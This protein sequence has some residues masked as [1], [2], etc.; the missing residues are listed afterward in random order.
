MTERANRTVVFITGAGHSGTT[1]LGLLLGAH[2]SVF[3]AG[4]AWNSTRLGAVRDDGRAVECTCCGAGCP[5]WGGL[6]PG[7]DGLGL[8][9]SPDLY[10]TLSVR[11]GR[12]VVV[13]SSKAVPWIEARS[14]A[15]RGV[16]PAHLLLLGRDGRAVVNSQLR[17]YP[18]VPARE[19]AARWAAQIR[20]AEELAG[21]WP[22]PVSRLHYE[23]LA[24]MTEDVLQQ[25]ARSLGLAFEPAMLDPWESEQHPLGGNRGTHSLLA[26][27]RGARGSRASC[28]SCA[29]GAAEEE[30][31]GGAGRRA[32]YARHPPAVV[33]DLRWHQEMPAD[34]LA[35]FDEVAGEVNIPYAR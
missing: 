11:S 4:E 6:R 12:P 7:E 31:P 3:H 35:V 26:R 16:V 30:F 34:A 18:H 2:P 17:K 24:M 27:S 29:S 25:Q 22:G 14:A 33:L 8:P 19:H 10:E 15:V 20:A 32:Y 9:G 5:V 21:R 1:L 23:D 13:D 28:A